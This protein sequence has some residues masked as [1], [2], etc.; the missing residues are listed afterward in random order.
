MP[1]SDIPGRCIYIISCFWY[2]TLPEEKLGTGA[3]YYIRCSL[4]GLG[5]LL[6]GT[7]SRAG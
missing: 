1:E 5:V 6:G 4:A 2:Y 7:G 3:R